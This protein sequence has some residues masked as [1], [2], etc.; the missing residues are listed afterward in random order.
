MGKITLDGTRD[1]RVFIGGDYDFMPILQEIAEFVR[2]Q[3]FVPVIAYDHNVPPGAIHDEDLALLKE[4][5]YA[6][7]E[8]SHPA[9]HLMELERAADYEETICFVVYPQRSEENPEPPPNLSEMV[10][11]LLI[12]LFEE[13]RGYPPLGYARFE[14][15]ENFIKGIFGGVTNYEAIY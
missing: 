12:K 2:S 10:K 15:L 3:H 9:G 8:M 13:G 5:K 4:C 6:I 1:K 14:H 11:L 7:F